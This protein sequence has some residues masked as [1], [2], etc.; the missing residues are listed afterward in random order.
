MKPASNYR[1]VG[2]NKP[3]TILIMALLLVMAFLSGAIA[4]RTDNII[5]NLMVII[6]P[7]IEELKA[8]FRE[9]L[10]IKVNTLAD[11][12]KWGSI[13]IISIFEHRLS[14]VIRGP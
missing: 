12:L 5:Q 1:P 13:I 9:Q 8:F 11:C 3:K 2:F 7:A 6:P 14:S 10:I 4:E